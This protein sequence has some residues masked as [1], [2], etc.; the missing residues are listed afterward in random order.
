VDEQ[1]YNPVV[2]VKVGDRRPSARSCGITHQKYQKD[3]ERKIQEPNLH[4]RV[5]EKG[6][7]PASRSCYFF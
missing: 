5:C 6:D 7:I 2:P 1:S 3:A 4:D